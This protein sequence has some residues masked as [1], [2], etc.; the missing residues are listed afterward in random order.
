MSVVADTLKKKHG[1]LLLSDGG[2]VIGAADGIWK[3]IAAQV[4]TELERGHQ[5]RRLSLA[6]PRQ[7][8]QFL[9]AGKSEAIEA[10]VLHK[11]PGRKVQGALARTSLTEDQRDQFGVA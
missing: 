7:R 11:Q 3:Q 8:G 10:A 1:K 5:R 2:Q 4:P 6:D 9:G